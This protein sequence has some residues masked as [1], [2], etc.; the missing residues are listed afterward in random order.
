MEN[1]DIPDGNIQASSLF[2][3]NYPAHDGRL[4]ANRYWAAQGSTHQPWIQADIGYQTYVSGVATQGYPTSWVTSIKVS[5]FY[6]TNADD[7]IFV[8]EDGAVAKVNNF[9]HC[10]SLTLILYTKGSLPP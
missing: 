5:T 9:L 3:S 7:E 8:S 4:N 1:G 2:D 6:M 10:I